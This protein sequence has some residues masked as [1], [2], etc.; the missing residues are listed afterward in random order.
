MAAVAICR[1]MLPAYSTHKAT[2]S[3]LR[4]RRPK[5]K[6]IS[7]IAASTSAVGSGMFP[8]RRA[9]K[10]P[11]PLLAMKAVLNKRKSRTSL[12]KSPFKSPPK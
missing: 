4:V 11:A 9:A 5:A 8:P 7:P 1:P 12:T 10:A 6:P 2:S 3:T